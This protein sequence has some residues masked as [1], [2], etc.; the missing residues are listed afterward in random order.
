MGQRKGLNVGDQQS[1]KWQS[2]CILGNSAVDILK[3]LR[4][5]RQMVNEEKESEEGHMALVSYM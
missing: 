3:Q 1:G 5:K 2:Y 4:M